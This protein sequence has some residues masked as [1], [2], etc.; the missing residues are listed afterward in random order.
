MGS[1]GDAPAKPSASGQVT[2]DVL[3]LISAAQKVPPKCV[4][5]IVNHPADS[6]GFRSSPFCATYLALSSSQYK[7]FAEQTRTSTAK[8]LLSDPSVQSAAIQALKALS[9]QTGSSV[10]TGGST[11]L[12]AKG[13]T[14]QFLS[15]ASEFGALTESTSGQTTTIAGTLAGVPLVL[16]KDGLLQSCPTNLYGILGKSEGCASP[17][18]I[19]T[20]S[21]ISY[22]VGIN[23]NTGSQAQSVTVN[24]TST[25]PAV[26]GAF[27]SSGSTLSVTSVTAKWIAL[28]GKPSSD[29]VTAGYKQFTQTASLV[30]TRNLASDL[31]DMEPIGDMPGAREMSDFQAET[32]KAI[33]KP[34]ANLPSPYSKEVVAQAVQAWKD[35]ADKFVA[36]FKTPTTITKEEAG[37]SVF[38][39]D[40]QKFAVAYAK[41][42]A[43]EQ[44]IG[45]AMARP[46]ILTF[47]YDNNRPLNQPSNSVF[48]VIYQAKLGQVTLTA[49]GA[50]SIY[51]S[52]PSSSIPGS[53]RLRDVQ[54]A[55][56]ADRT[57]SPTIPIFG[58]TSMTGSG[59][60][61][62]QDQTTPSI[63][64]VTPGMP[65]SGVSFTGLPSTA[66]QVFAQ[67]GNIAVG[68]AKLTLGSG[69]NLKMPISVTY[70][71]RTELVT[72]PVWRGQ[73]GISYDFDS[74]FTKR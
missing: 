54:F 51:D 67:K 12:T 18:L 69:S 3:M 57:F 11:N 36:L 21:R 63:L 27:S 68:Q 65:V 8:S 58:K 28:E 40:V 29:A 14:S 50:A 74:L 10:G 60:F 45:V 2:A 9:Q 23:S 31:Q 59:S 15:L 41:T 34:L 72:S 5:Q 66:T 26:P 13:L 64:N 6:L 70:S 32:V 71:N 73:I 48:R 62:F 20:L 52:T 56:E 17:K 35:S 49:N 53:E 55:A 19:E 16:L 46:A 43:Q 22:S 7:K 47:E 25:A 39:A 38:L 33:R 44:A 4:D 30:D 61:Y 24:T 1:T 42:I 37:Q